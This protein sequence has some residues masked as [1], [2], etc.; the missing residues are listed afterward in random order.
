MNMFYLRTFLSAATIAGA[1]S[2][3]G[4]VTAVD[5][6][7]CTAD[8]QCGNDQFCDTTPSCHDGKATG[9]CTTK[10][11]MCTREYM[12]VTGCDG[13]TYANKCEAKAAGQ[14]ISDR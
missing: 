4:C 7:R 5:P 1:L 10:P 3:A 12:P 9:V 11:M 6:N 13:K 8:S 2:L 14:V